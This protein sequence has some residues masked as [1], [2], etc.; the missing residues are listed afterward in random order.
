MRSLAM[1]VLFMIAV[2]N[3]VFAHERRQVAGNYD[4]VV[5]FVNEPAF[6]SQMNGVDLQVTSG[7][8]PVEGLETT[9]KVIVRYGDE[10]AG[11]DIP[12]K[13]K[14]RNLGAYAAY[15]RPAKPGKYTFEITGTLNGRYV[16]E[17]FESGEKF[18]DVEDSAAISWPQSGP[19]PAAAAQSFESVLQPGETGVNASNPW[20]AAEIAPSAPGTIT[21]QKN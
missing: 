15:F 20:P 4:F 1:F 21:A 17:V 8:Q 11:L 7:G 13:A 6:S 3:P 12:F 10:T 19:L 16:R 18:H 5:G 2:G 9:M 14:Y